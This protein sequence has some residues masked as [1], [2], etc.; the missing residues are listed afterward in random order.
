MGEDVWGPKE[1]P[2]HGDALPFATQSYEEALARLLF[3]SERHWP[4]GLLLGPAGCGKSVL[5]RSL[6]NELRRLGSEATLI[7]LSGLDGD[8]FWPT[9]A[10]ALGSHD[11]AEGLAARK[12]VRA[13]LVASA[14][15]NR[16]VTLLLDD[17]DRGGMGLIDQVSALVRLAEGVTPSHTIIIASSRDLPNSDLSERVDLRAELRPFTLE[18]TRAYLSHRLEGTGAQLSFDPEA[19]NDV[20]AVSGGIPAVIDRIADLAVVA[21]HAQDANVITAEMI[22]T[23]A[24]ELRPVSRAV[25]TDFD[26]VGRSYTPRSA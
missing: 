17:A 2:F 8:E 14:M 16:P 21:A 3:M 4:A 18:E 12:T 15:I 20:F 1:L 25:A 24:T 7:S 19:I 11:A 9:I 5:L 10:A 13:L 26:H 6:R 22:R 23:A